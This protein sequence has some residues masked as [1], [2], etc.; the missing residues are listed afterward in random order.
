MKEN[1]DQDHVKRGLLSF[2]GKIGK[3]A[4]DFPGKNDSFPSFDPTF[5]PAPSFNLAFSPTQK[6]HFCNEQ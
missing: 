4:P 2:Q 6:L 5:P 1:L 3:I